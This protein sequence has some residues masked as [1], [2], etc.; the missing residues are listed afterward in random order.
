MKVN[1]QKLVN[2]W[3]NLMNDICC[4]YLTINTT[5]SELERQKLYYDIEDGITVAWMLKEAEYWLSCYYESGH[6]RCDD[7]FEGENEYKTWV[8]ETGRLKRLIATL[9]KME[10]TLIVEWN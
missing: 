10:N 4:E 9:E 6:C 8:S 3:N 7:R 1:N 5:Q 2:R